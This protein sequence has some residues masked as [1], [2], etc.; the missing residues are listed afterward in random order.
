[1]LGSL[2]GGEL[3]PEILCETLVELVLVEIGCQVRRVGL[4]GRLAVVLVAEPAE[5][6]LDPLAL[7]RQKLACP[8]SIH[9]VSLKASSSATGRLRPTGLRAHPALVCATRNAPL[10][11]APRLRKR[12]SP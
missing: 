8:I 11:R 7:S 4:V 6:V 12:G 3:L 9:S 2:D 10:A 5:R 1:L